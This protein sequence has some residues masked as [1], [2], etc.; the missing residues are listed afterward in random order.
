MAQIEIPKGDGLPMWAIVDRSDL[1]GCT[2][3]FT[4]KQKANDPDT[5]IIFQYTS[6]DGEITF[7]G[8]RADWTIQGSDT[9]G[10]E[11]FT[12]YV[13]DVRY[14]GPDNIPHTVDVGTLKVTP[15]VRDE[16]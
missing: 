4:V 12:Q 16:V 14:K 6:T 10:L 1:R 7:S 13:W 11:E 15:T 5:S 9:A 2:M 8:N 3:Y